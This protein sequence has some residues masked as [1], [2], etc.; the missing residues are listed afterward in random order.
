M[1]KK[2]NQIMVLYIDNEN[3]CFHQILLNDLEL[4]RISSE[5]GNIFAAKNS[6]VRVSSTRLQIYEEAKENEKKENSREV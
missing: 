2:E 5:I 1:D 3:R 4:S 6:A